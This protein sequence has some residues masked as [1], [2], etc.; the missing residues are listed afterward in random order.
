MHRCNVKSVHGYSLLKRLTHYKRLKTAAAL[1]CIF[2]IYIFELMLFLE[3]KFKVN[4][5]FSFY[6]FKL[7]KSLGQQLLNTVGREQ[8]TKMY[9]LNL[10]TKLFLRK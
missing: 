10:S 8:N 9:Y 3:S 2:I 7:R 6:T 4:V 1:Y 5:S